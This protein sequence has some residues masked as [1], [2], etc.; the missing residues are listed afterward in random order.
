MNPDKVQTEKILR[1]VGAL[2]N[3][4]SKFDRL[5][6]AYRMAMAFIDPEGLPLHA[7]DQAGLLKTLRNLQ[8]EIRAVK[9]KQRKKSTR[10]STNAL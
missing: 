9:A 7:T 2:V 8:K 10:R 4:L 1:E 5:T 3:Q 6:L